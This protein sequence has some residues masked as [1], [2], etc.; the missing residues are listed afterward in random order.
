MV[1]QDAWEIYG[2]TGLLELNDP[3]HQD[4]T[5]TISQYINPVIDAN[6]CLTEFTI[7]MNGA[8]G[9]AFLANENGIL[10]CT[11][12]LIITNNSPAT[13]IIF[14]SLGDYWINLLGTTTIYGNSAELIFITPYKLNCNGCNFP[15][16][17]KVTFCTI[18]ISSPIP[19]GLIN[20][21][22]SSYCKT[23]EELYL[24]MNSD[25]R[26][27]VV[28]PGSGLRS[29]LEHWVRWGS[30]EKSK[31]ERNIPENYFNE[32]NFLEANHDVRDA[33]NDPNYPL[34]SGLDHY[35]HHVHAD[36]TPNGAFF[37]VPRSISNEHYIY[38]G[39][40]GLLS[41]SVDLYIVAGSVK[42]IGQIA[43]H[44]LDVQGN[45]LLEFW[46]K[47]HSDSEI[48]IREAVL[49]ITHN[50]ADMEAV[51]RI[52]L[53]AARLV[54]LHGK[55]WSASNNVAIKSHGLD[56][57][58]LIQAY[59]VFI[60]VNYVIMYGGTIETQNYIMFTVSERIE[61][62][63]NTKITANSEIV[64]KGLNINLVLKAHL[65]S[66]TNLV[67]K[68]PQI[69]ISNL[70]RVIIIEPHIEVSAT[71]IVTL[72]S[73]KLVNK[74]LVKAK[75]K[76]LLEISSGIDN[77]GSIQSMN[78]LIINA[79]YMY[80]FAYSKVEAL[81]SLIATIK[82]SITLYDHA[83]FYS[84]GKMILE[85]PN[86]GMLSQLINV[87]SAKFGSGNDANIRSNAI[88]VH[89]SVGFKVGSNPI[90][91]TYDQYGNQWQAHVTMRCTNQFLENG[92]I[93]EAEFTIGGSLYFDGNSI[94][95]HQSYFGI[96]GDLRLEKPTY[97]EILGL[98]WSE[99]IL[100]QWE[101]LYIRKG[102]AYNRD[103]LIYIPHQIHVTFFVEGQPYGEFS[104][105]TSIAKAPNTPMQLLQ[106]NMGYIDDAKVTGGS[107][108]PIEHNH[109]QIVLQTPNP[110]RVVTP[111]D[112][113]FDTAKLTN[114][115]AE[116]NNI[117]VTPKETAD[118]APLVD[119][120]HKPLLT[121]EYGTTYLLTSLGVNKS[122]YPQIFGSPDIEKELIKNGMFC[123]TGLPTIYEFTQ[124]QD[125]FLQI[126]D[127]SND[128]NSQNIPTD[129]ACSQLKWLLLNGAKL[130][131]QYG[132]VVGE[133]LAYDKISSIEVPF[134]W[135]VVK[136]T[137]Q[138]GEKL[139]L[140]LY[141][142]QALIKNMPAWF[143]P[144]LLLGS[145][146]LDTKGNFISTGITY[147]NDGA[148]IKATN[149]GLSGAFIVKNGALNLDATKTIVNV[150]ASVQTFNGTIS[151]QAE[152]IYELIAIDSQ[153]KDPST[154]KRAI[155]TINGNAYYLAEN[156]IEQQATIMY[157]S[158]NLTM[159]AGGDI[160]QS[161]IHK[162]RKI[163]EEWGKNYH[164]VE[165]TID[166][167]DMMLLVN[168]NV[169]LDADG[170]YRGS[171]IKIASGGDVN[172]NADGKAT[173]ETTTAY[174]HNSYDAKKRRPLG[175]SKISM[176]WTTSTTATLEI[177]APNGNL[178]ISSEECVLEGVSL[179]GNKPVLHCNKLIDIAREIKNIMHVTTKR[180]GLLAPK[181]P[182]VDLAKS[183]DKW[184]DIKRNS[185]IGSVEQLFKMQ[186]A[187]DLLPAI[188]LVASLPTFKADYQAL[189]GL[190]ANAPVALLGAILSK[191]ISATISFGTQR[192]ETHRT[193]IR[194]AQSKIEGDS[195]EITGK[196]GASGKEAFLSGNYHCGENLYIAFDNLK[197]AGAKD[198]LEQTTEASG[199]SFDI[200]ASLS[201]VSFGV[202]VYD[203]MSSYEQTV[204]K[205]GTF[206]A[207]QVTILVNEK[208]EIE[209]AMVNGQTVIVNASEIEIKQVL[210]TVRQEHESTGTSIGVTV[211]WAGAV[212]PYGSLNY[213]DG[214]KQSQMMKFISGISGND[215]TVTTK[216]LM[217]NVASITGDE[218]LK[219][220]ADK[221]THT[222][223]PEAEQ[224]DTETKIMMA[225]SAGADGKVRG[226]IAGS[227]KDG[228][229]VISGGYF[230][231][232][233]E[234]LDII[235]D[236]LGISSDNL[237]NDQDEPDD[238]LSQL[239][240]DDEEGE[241]DEDD[242][243]PAD[244]EEEDNKKDKDKEKDKDKSKPKSNN[245]DIKAREE[246][247]NGFIKAGV[248]PEIAK[249]I[250]LKLHKDLR[251]YIKARQS[252]DANYKPTQ[253]EMEFFV[254]SRLEYY[255]QPIL[256]ADA[257]TATMGLGIGA[258]LELGAAATACVASVVC[259]AALAVT[260]VAGVG[261]YYATKPDSTPGLKTKE[262]QPDTYGTPPEG[263]D[264]REKKIRDQGWT[265]NKD[266]NWHHENANDIEGVHN[267]P[268]VGN[269]RLSKQLDEI[270]RPTNKGPG[271]TAG[272][273]RREV[274]QGLNKQHLTK[275]EERIT[276]LNRI[277]KEES[278]SRD[279]RK[280]T[281]RIISDLRDAI[282]KARG[283]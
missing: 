278:L 139:L 88:I 141:L 253:A 201:G 203:A 31:N 33:V 254:K 92:H 271:G 147:V 272:E 1:A 10:V 195:C 213:A 108:V 191:Y 97:L 209:A 54:D 219:I 243:K 127:G 39:S 241:D 170:N 210:D 263:D 6:G 43:V 42:A 214:V 221:I 71:N 169:T 90:S 261:I 32:Q 112:Q 144:A 153:N 194:S 40:K 224:I 73:D 45:S 21:D 109:R 80:L 116:N 207:R 200:G 58:Q 232:F 267:R 23:N 256:L 205:A 99:C 276:N 193:D 280:T 106:P 250:S 84:Y 206:T 128:S 235:K 146:N 115:P 174:A 182:L 68:A 105:I 211:T 240:A 91:K 259:I 27:V 264:D 22:P 98:S 165:H 143:G 26:D 7:P 129:K 150:G 246:L 44:K 8:T 59:L 55:V 249:E 180:S 179:Q 53:G 223:M 175:S 79:Q 50:N 274:E 82:D 196:D 81:T 121:C 133:S 282:N 94:A 159:H 102:E 30:I 184:D 103:R 189:Q 76:T 25:V 177:I 137:E 277:I 270:Y 51:G 93:N 154:T 239:E 4:F 72:Q 75:S 36:G 265:K 160:T 101:A 190:G 238:E 242:I 41:S 37:G 35:V 185:I 12:G 62:S 231:S 34:K 11:G 104:G 215:V 164:L 220:E 107:L 275:A 131:D 266:G 176:Q 28:K 18:P 9:D 183:N 89:R 130:K 268:N 166:Q 85:A 120:L 67:L 134:A 24:N 252:Q 78:E 273:L 262:K 111:E 2:N 126:T 257:S 136:K 260:A 95:I 167:Y 29:A 38:I 132:L 142:P 125:L 148:V 212:I 152:N 16:L 171:G 158:G 117:K 234:G 5:V 255:G 187:T 61:L 162:E 172:I 247:E 227:Y 56:T 83:T 77:H 208:L 198:K 74:G 229:F 168:G 181:V 48:S 236:G 281:E 60:D 69:K 230:S 66:N 52:Y 186:S 192:T 145:F 87:I 161:T 188:N 65:Q 63:N 217:Y 157:I 151:L 70:G 122:L 64:I 96:T 140:E 245:K 110:N 119:N 199:E 123:L 149:I 258:S 237:G 57:Y 248:K 49:I 14:Q 226:S 47:V 156:N 138:F 251:H 124:I 100:P 204:N 20:N 222:A 86:R 17:M 178:Y 113:V 173:L 216:H 118:S 3:G 135:P 233:M 155:Y 218:S 228:D 163:R 225:L 283:N 279:D 46:S 269:S 202:S 15:S 19:G 244:S 197:L 13:R 114:V